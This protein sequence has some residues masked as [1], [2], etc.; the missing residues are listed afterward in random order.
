MKGSI[1]NKSIS[2][3]GSWKWKDE[4]PTRETHSGT[5]CRFYELHNVPLS[6]LDL[7][8]IRFLIGQNTELEYLVPYAFS[9]LNENI[10]IEAEY[11]SGDLLCALFLINDEPNYWQTHEEEKQE[12]IEL[13]QEQKSN[14]GSVEDQEIIQKIKNAYK[15]FL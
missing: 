6:E 7:S 1:S 2:E 3:L 13:Y 15:E 12:I 8:D 14:L 5:Q 9:K 10:F 11:Y 4:I